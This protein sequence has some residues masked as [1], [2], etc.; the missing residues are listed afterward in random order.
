MEETEELVPIKFEKVMQ[1]RAY[2]CIV[3]GT[4]EKKF[5]IY[6]D[7]AS[8]KAMQ[9]YLTSSE[10]QRPLTHDLIIHLFQG[11]DIKIKQIVLIDLQDTVYFARLF[12]EQQIH[13]VLHIVEIDARPSDCINLALLNKV[14]IYCTQKVLEETISYEE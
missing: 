2:T 3:L 11:L 12:L 14:P 8:G 6:T 4:D 10:K 1:S 13:D 7:S 5:A 9:V